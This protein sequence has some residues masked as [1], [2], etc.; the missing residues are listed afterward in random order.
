[1][2]LAPPAPGIP[3]IEVDGLTAGYGDRILFRDVSFRVLA[4]EVFVILGGSG[5]G[6]STL[7]KLLIGLLRPLSGSIRVLGHDIVSG[8]EKGMRAV[9]SRIGVLFQAGG[10]LNS[11]TVGENVALPLAEHTHL[12]PA[13]IGEL[14][15][16]KLALVDLSHAPGLLPSEISGGMKKRAGLA[17][18]L[19]L[20]PHLL[21]LDEPS[22]GLD[23]VTSL[24]LDLLI[25]SINEGTG[26]TMVLVTHELDSIFRIAHRIIFLDRAAKGIIAEGDPRELRDRSA[27][28]RVSD[29][30]NRRAPSRNG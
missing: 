24:E 27:D 25:G 18:A 3:V 1:M 29:F 26:S 5:C 9:R 12:S 6:K 21:F 20:D 22:A 4:G 28:P 13:A 2:N 23:P 17:R 7:L 8:D 15:R 30:L 19:A 10:L 14:V 11:M 16:M